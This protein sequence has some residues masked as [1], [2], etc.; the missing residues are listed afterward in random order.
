[1]KGCV[2]AWKELMN[3][4]DAVAIFLILNFKLCHGDLSGS[5]YMRWPTVAI[6][7]D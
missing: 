6:I 5:A 1:M 2:F 4:A 7:F 3:K